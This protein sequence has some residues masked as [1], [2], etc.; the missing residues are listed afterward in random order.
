[1]FHRAKNHGAD[2][3][4]RGAVARLLALAAIVATGFAQ[5]STSWHEASVQHVRCAEHGEITHVAMVANPVPSPI[6]RHNVV[7][8]SDP[9]APS[10]GHDHCDFVFA[11]QGSAQN[12][13]VRVAITLPP[14]PQVAPRAVEP[15]PLPGRTFVLASAPKTSPPSA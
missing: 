11:V 6:A 14:P 7:G 4:G 1:M 3:H 5:F 9:V 12:R 10:G 2:Q 15:A 13:V 8:A